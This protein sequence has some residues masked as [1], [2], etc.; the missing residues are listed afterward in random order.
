MTGRCSA[1]VPAAQKRAQPAALDDQLGPWPEA[2]VAMFDDLGLAEDEIARHLRIEP[3][4]VRQLRA[5]AAAPDALPPWVD[6][7]AIPPTGP[8]P[9]QGTPIDPPRPPP[10]LGFH[11][12]LWECLARLWRR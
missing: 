3:A 4:K 8:M 7:P 5:R 6:P 10:G 2:T 12:R 9:P 1:M 11:L